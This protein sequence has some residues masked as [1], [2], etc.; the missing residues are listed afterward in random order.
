MDHLPLAAAAAAASAP[1]PAAGAQHGRVLDAY[2]KA[3]ATA[4]SVAAYAV[5][6]RSMAREL[7]PDELRAAARWGAAFVRA[8]LGASE[9]ERHTVVIRRQLDGGYSENQLF[10]AARAYLATK[11]DPRALR[12]LSLAR[13]RCKEADGSSSWTTLLCLEPGDSTTDVF[14]GVEFRWTSMETGGGDD[15][16]RGGKG[17]GDRGHRAPRE[18][19][20][21]SFDAEHTDTALERYVPFVMATAEQLQRRERVLRIFM[22]EVRSWHGFNHHHPATFDTI[23]ME[24]DLK[25]SIVDDLDRFLKRKEYYRR[26]GKAWKR[27]YLLHGP[28]G[29]GKSSLVAAMANY[30][31]FN[32]YDL[33][34]SEVRVNAALQRLLISMPN[35]SILVIED[36]DCCFD[37]NPRE[38]HKITTAALDQAEDFDFSSSDSDDAVGAPP[39]ARRA[40]D[41]QQQ[42]LTLSGLLNFIDGLWSTSGEERVIVFTT[43]YKERLDPALLRP[44]RMDMHVYMGYCGW[45]AFKTLA[46]NYFLVGDHPLFPEIRQLLAGVEVTPAEVSEML[47]RS[48]DADA[49]LRGLVEFLRERTRRRARQEAAIDDNQVVAEKGNAA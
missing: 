46:H 33:D 43:N 9:K 26:I 28:P 45:E 38:A 3:L 15:G 42:K 1:S 29:T 30:L 17:G 44:G 6:A 13:S 4:A 23:A 27:G 34:L 2:K 20:E 39:R 18:S 31:R 49:A 19:L 12:R 11:I 37:A 47:L 32:L 22:N 41:L 5:L 48:E 40:G 10:E 7:L 8:R 36:I 35:K 16:K 14:D 21:L 25:K 24:P